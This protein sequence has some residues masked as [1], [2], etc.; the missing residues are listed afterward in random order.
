MCIVH[1]YIHSSNY[2]LSSVTGLNKPE[3]LMWYLLA[4]Q[5][6]DGGRGLIEGSNWSS[7]V[8]STPVTWAGRPPRVSPVDLRVDEGVATSRAVGVWTGCLCL[9][10]Q[11]RYPSLL[12]D[13]SESWCRLESGRRRARITPLANTPLLKVQKRGGWD[14]PLTPAKSFTSSRSCQVSDSICSNRC[15]DTFLIHLWGC[16]GGLIHQQLDRLLPLIGWNSLLPPSS[17]T[18]LWVYT[19]SS[20]FVIEWKITQA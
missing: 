20:S 18:F 3:R 19:K 16:S 8:I 14:S 5:M 10:S 15:Q 2:S 13:D 7:C 17:F 9:P 4:D 12:T 6:K 1:T 11:P